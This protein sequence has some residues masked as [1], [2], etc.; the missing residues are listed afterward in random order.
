MAARLKWMKKNTVVISYVF[1]IWFKIIRDQMETRKVC[2]RKIIAWRFYMRNAKKR[3]NLFRLCFWPFY[4]WRKYVSKKAVGKEKAKFLVLRVM[5]TVLT[6]GVFRAWKVYAHQESA[7]NRCANDFFKKQMDN[8]VKYAYSWL[9]YWSWQ[10]RVIRHAWI[11]RGLAMRRKVT[12][13]R[14]NTPFQIWKAYAHF[15][16][17]V[18]T[19]LAIGGLTFKAFFAP[20]AIPRPFYTKP[21]KKKRAEKE[22]LRLKEE[23]KRQVQKEIR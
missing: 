5:P 4:V 22:A 12:F 8:Q 11:A 18:R 16:R 9:R 13:K 20:K 6:M 17:L 2:R 10:R 7:I 14:Q 3:R 19:R 1:K 23:A 21:M 15:K